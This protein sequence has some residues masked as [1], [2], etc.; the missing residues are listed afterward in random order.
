MLAAA[1]NAKPSTG[2][3]LLALMLNQLLAVFPGFLGIALGGPHDLR[4]IQVT[5]A[6]HLPEK[7]DLRPAIPLTP[8]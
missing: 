1:R 5:W 2:I 3:S 6:M 7:E 8:M 4:V